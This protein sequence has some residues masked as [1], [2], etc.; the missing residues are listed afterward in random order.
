M[1]LK[2]ACKF[3]LLTVNARKCSNESP[4]HFVSDFIEMEW[5]VFCNL[6]EYLWLI[7]FTF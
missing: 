4:F 2:P 7:K 1:N 3:T 6:V 5:A